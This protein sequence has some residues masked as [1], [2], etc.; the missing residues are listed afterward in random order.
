MTFI[1]VK[2]IVW[3]KFKTLSTEMEICFEKLVFEEKIK[4]RCR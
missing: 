2:K 4:N 3:Q 1:D